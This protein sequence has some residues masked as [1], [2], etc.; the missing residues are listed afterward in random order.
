MAPPDYDALDVRAQATVATTV[1]RTWIKDLLVVLTG[2][3]AVAAVGGPGKSG[4]IDGNPQQ[5]LIQLYGIAVTAVYSALAS[6]FLLKLV[7]WTIGLR[8]DPETEREGLDLVLHGE[9]VP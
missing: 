8:V 7:D 4:L 2:A 5:V 1:S 9:A 3:L 6:L